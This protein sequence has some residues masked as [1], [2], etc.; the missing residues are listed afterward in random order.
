M[1]KLRER[2]LYTERFDIL[3]LAGS[4]LAEVYR[5][6]DVHTGEIVALKLLPRRDERDPELRGRLENEARLLSM[7]RHESIVALKDCGEA[8]SGEFFLTTEFLEGESLR[9]YLAREGAMRESVALP[10][11]GSVA[12][13]LAAAHAAGIVHRDVKPDNVFLCGPIGEP[14][15]V[16]L[17]DFGLARSRCGGE[18]PRRVLGTFEYMAPEQ[19]VTDPADAR[20]DVYGIG[21]VMFRT[22]TGELPFDTETGAPLL[23]HHLLSAA[24]PPT[25][26]VESLS[27]DVEIIVLTAL[28]KHPDNRYQSMFQLVEDLDRVAVGGRAKGARQ[29]VDPDVYTPLSDLGLQA[30]EILGE[31]HGHDVARRNSD[32]PRRAQ[33]ESHPTPPPSDVTERAS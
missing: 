12:R 5:A 11:L 31:R 1:S 23:A 29:V 15:S 28:R 8:I 30:L 20:S 32:R 6:R 25:W 7:V 22:L 33:P 14:H 18:E 21:A 2:D 13:A 26:L 4:G 10:L 16:R 3:G 19:V 9:S 27:R 24:P 17:L